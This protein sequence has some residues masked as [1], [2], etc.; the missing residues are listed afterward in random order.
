MPSVSIIDQL[1]PEARAWL[2]AELAKRGFSG[3]VDVTAEL[4][5]RLAALGLEITVGKSSVGRHGKKLKEDVEEIRK[6]TE[7]ARALVEASEDEQANL[8]AASISVAQVKLLGALRGLDAED[9]SPKD[10]ANLTRAIAQVSTADRHTKRYRE[11]VR[12]R[13]EAAA[14]KAETIARKG[15]L[16]AA[17]IEEIKRQFLGI[18][19]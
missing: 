14:A 9:V 10:I 2:D 17:T 13:A 11:E 7:A 3:Y 19:A 15:G 5:N 1:P 16:S 6:A 18:A 12:K 8:A 4:N